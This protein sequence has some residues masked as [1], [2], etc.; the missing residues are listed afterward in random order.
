MPPPIAA[1]VN[2]ATFSPQPRYAASSSIPSLVM[3]V[4]STSKHTA[5]A[6]WSA[7]LA[8]S[9]RVPMWAFR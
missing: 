1:A 6:C 3:T 5:S 2:S 8:W 7:H 9:T 4:E